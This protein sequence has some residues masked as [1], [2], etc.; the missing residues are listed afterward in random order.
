M[1]RNR[2]R[3]G[4]PRQK[5]GP[6]QDLDSRVAGLVLSKALLAVRYPRTFDALHASLFA[7][8]VF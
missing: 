6:M 5:T 1:S 7:I 2:R 3:P 4:L 8:V